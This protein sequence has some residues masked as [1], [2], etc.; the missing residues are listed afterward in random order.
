MLGAVFGAIFGA[1]VHAA[2]GGRRDFD[3][4]VQTQAR[5]Y[6]IQVDEGFAAE[7][8]RLLARMPSS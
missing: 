7:A 2:T 6:E 4:V 1:T 5:R 8:E 3:S